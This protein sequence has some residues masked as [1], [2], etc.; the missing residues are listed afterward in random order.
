MPCRV[1]NSRAVRYTGRVQSA[2]PQREW[3]EWLAKLEAFRQTFGH[4]RGP[5]KWPGDPGLAKWVI[6]QR[7]R[8]HQLSLEQLEELY[9]FGF[10]F[11]SLLAGVRCRVGGR[12]MPICGDGFYGSVTESTP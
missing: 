11:G 7:N 8:F 2:C 10:D 1:P 9:R 6:E 3:R 4:C 12:K 5:S